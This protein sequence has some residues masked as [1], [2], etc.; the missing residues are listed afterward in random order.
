MDKKVEK[1]IV[2]AIEEAK[3]SFAK[4]IEESKL[5]AQIWLYIMN[6]IGHELNGIAKQQYAQ[7]LKDY[8]NEI[9]NNKED[10]N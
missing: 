9:D 4:L 1:P 2:V 8:K 6:D 5:P 10:T 7:Q 3:M